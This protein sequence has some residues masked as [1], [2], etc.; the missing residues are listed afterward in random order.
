M[1][2]LMSGSCRMSWRRQLTEMLGG[3]GGGGYETF[4]CFEKN[5]LILGL[6]KYREPRLSSN[7]LLRT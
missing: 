5:V 4:Q 2:Y 7:V 1:L 6:G 3:G